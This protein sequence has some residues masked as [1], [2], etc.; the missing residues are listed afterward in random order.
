MQVSLWSGAAF[1]LPKNPKSLRHFLEQVAKE[2]GPLP[3]VC[4]AL[5]PGYSM[6]EYSLH[7][8]A[9]NSATFFSHSLAL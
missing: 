2:S 3:F 4:D 1:T 9:E 5:S 7:Y 8:R 6:A